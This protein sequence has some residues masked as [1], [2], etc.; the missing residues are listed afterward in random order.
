MS[1]VYKKY[2][3]RLNIIFKCLLIELIYFIKTI[4]FTICNTYLQYINLKHLILFTNY[5]ITKNYVIT[6]YITMNKHIY[7]CYLLKIF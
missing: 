2:C 3:V 5:F 6:Y 1:I 4:L 7:S